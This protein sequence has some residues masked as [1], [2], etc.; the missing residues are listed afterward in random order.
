[1]APERWVL[2]RIV[3]SVLVVA[4]SLFQF[5]VARKYRLPEANEFGLR[6]L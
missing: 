3:V 5:T 6:V 4:F 2:F 1:L